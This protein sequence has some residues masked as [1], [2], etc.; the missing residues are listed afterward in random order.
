MFSKGVWW[1]WVLALCVVGPVWA[2]SFDNAINAVQLRAYRQDATGV[3]VRGGVNLSTGAHESALFNTNVQIGGG[4]GAFNF[5]GSIK[6]AFEDIPQ[7]LEDLAWGV[8]RSLPMVVICSV[9]PV[10]CDIAKDINNYLNVLI[11]A[12]FAQCQNTQNAAMY[13]GLRLRGGQVSQC[14]S[15][16]VGSMGIDRAMRVCNEEPFTLRKPDGS[17]GPE[18]NLIQDTLRAAGADPE[19]RALAKAFLGD[20][21]LRTGDTFGI[22][23]QSP[24]EAMA[25]RYDAHKQEYAIHLDEA[26]TAYQATG[27]VSDYST[28]VLSVPGQPMPHVAIEKLA[29]LK[30]TDPV[31]YEALAASLSTAAAFSQITSE[32]HD[33]QN[34]IQAAADGNQHL[35][36]PELAAIKK[37]LERLRMTLAQMEETIGAAEKHSAAL[38]KVFVEYARTEQMV[39][40]LGVSAPA[41]QIQVPPARF[42]QQQPIGYAR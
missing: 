33:L 22:S 17:F 41:I 19:T 37:K 9:E 42:G 6:E 32:C 7:L 12:R 2:G 8:V 20:V 31:R 13:A 25:G 21:T 24:L 18:V 4:C 34:Q 10:V 16:K 3:T 36:E 27:T 29:A 26:V 5:Q 15:Q 35:S 1:S 14:L 38:D 39:S 23:A 28:V 40:R 11:N 30:N